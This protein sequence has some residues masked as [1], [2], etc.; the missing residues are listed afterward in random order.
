METLVSTKYA[1]SLN[2]SHEHLYV[3]CLTEWFSLIYEYVCQ[4]SEI[5]M[6]KATDTLLHNLPFKVTNTENFTENLGQYIIRS[7]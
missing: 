1:F 6:E 4:I 7:H 5:F 2:W 3:S